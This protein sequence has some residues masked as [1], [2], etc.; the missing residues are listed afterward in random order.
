M[1][2]AK[3]QSRRRL[4]GDGEVAEGDVVAASEEM[5]GRPEL[6]VRAAWRWWRTLLL[7]WRRRNQG[8]TQRRK[9]REKV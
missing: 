2:L 1:E 4:R 7:W 6:S 5:A 3:A 9:R 8:E